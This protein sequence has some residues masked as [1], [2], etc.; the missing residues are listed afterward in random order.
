MSIRIFTLALLFCSFTSFA[1]ELQVS[2]KINAPIVQLTDPKVFLTLESGIKDFLENQRWSEDAFEPEERIQVVINLTITEER[3]ATSYKA[4]LAIQSVR[5]V[6]KSNYETPMLSHV[7]RDVT[8]TYEQFQPLQF[9]Q[10]NFN[11][12]LS[13]I[14]AFYAFIIVGMDY[15]SFSPFGGERAFLNAQDVINAVPSAVAERNPGWRSIDGN[16]NRYWIVENMLSPRVRP[17]RQAMYDYHRQALDVMHKDTG[18]G[19]AIILACLEEINKVAQNYPNAMVVQMF[20]NAKSNEI[21]EIFKAGSPTEASKV[22]QIMTRLDAAN[23][24]KYRSLRS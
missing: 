4:D 13:S 1:Q 11:D 20:S 23:A 7:D 8:F 6:Y 9:S 16:R 24:A 18:A 14:L 3:S 22:V 5:P 15:E 17:L 2:V 10:N 12:N 19:R 21:M